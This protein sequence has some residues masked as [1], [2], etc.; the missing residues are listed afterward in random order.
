MNQDKHI[1]D[2]KNAIKK[3]QMLFIVGAGFSRN[4]SDHFPMWSDLLKP[5]A[6][7][8]YGAGQYRKASVR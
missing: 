5:M 1:I 2:I 6:E 8:L 4:I 7:E 3:R